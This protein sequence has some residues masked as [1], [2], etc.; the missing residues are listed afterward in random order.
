MIGDSII[1]EDIPKFHTR[2]GNVK[3]YEAYLNVIDMD[4]DS[5]DSIFTGVI[6]K[7]DKPV[8]NRINTSK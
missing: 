8:F 5:Q 7:L 4:Y 2:L 3:D 6:Y 1:G